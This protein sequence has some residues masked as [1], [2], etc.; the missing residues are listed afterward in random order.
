MSDETNEVYA[1]AKQKYC[2]AFVQ[3]ADRMEYAAPNEHKPYSR[4]Q[5]IRLLELRGKHEEAEELNAAFSAHESAR[6]QFL[7]AI[8]QAP[9]ELVSEEYA[10][11]YLLVEV[12][13]YVKLIESQERAREPLKEQMGTENG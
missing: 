13:A 10:E 2:N 1:G 5:L 9:K 12:M 3:L 8:K 11:I 4:Y 7:D 6:D